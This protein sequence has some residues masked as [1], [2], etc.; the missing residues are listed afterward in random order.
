[1]RR[2]LCSITL[3]AALF[4]TACGVPN[5]METLEADEAT[6]ES[7][8]TGALTLGA[9]WAAP[10][11]YVAEVTRELEG[12]S[13]PV[14]RLFR[15]FRPVTYTG[16]TIRDAVNAMLQLPPNDPDYASIWAR[17]AKVRSVVLSGDLA[18][19]DLTRAAARANAGSE[20][21]D[22]SVQQLVHTVT[23]AHTSVKRVLLTIDGRPVPTLWG[24]VSWVGP[25]SRQPRVSVISPVW[26]LT[27]ENNAMTARTFT[28]SG[29]ASV[30]EAS[31]S[32]ELRKGTR[33]INS[34]FTNAS[35]GAPE[36]GSFSV[37]VV[38]PAAGE[39]VVHAFT[40]SAMNGKVE[41][42]DTKAI[43]VR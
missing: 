11:Y 25:K 22:L 34:G 39:Y 33:I 19:V 17:D 30:F 12:G 27:P 38:A 20:L 8:S 32:W 37:N 13:Q 9:T 10:I 29:F 42:L 2:D 7:E 26:A 16:N 21:A 23:A 41:Y 6:I 36:T 24:S 1:M 18:T 15:E 35:V 3:F 43:T 40:T 5:D 4:L 14:F 31:V 28:L